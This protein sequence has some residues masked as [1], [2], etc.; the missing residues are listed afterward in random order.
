LAKSKK[1]ES[2]NH[3]A[4]E[5]IIMKVDI[6]CHIVPKRYLEAVRKIAPSGIPQQILIESTPT[7]T[8]LN[9]RFQIMDKYPD[10]V[11]V[12]TLASPPI[13]AIAG[14]KESAELARIANDEMAE[15]VSKHPQR[16][17]AA[18]GSL[19]M[20][21]VEAAL[22]ELDRVINGL[23][24]RGIQIYTNMN[25]KPIDSPEFIP[26]YQRMS[27]LNLPI[28]LHPKRE[29][30]TPDYVTEKR[31]KYLMNSIFGWPHETSLAMG[32]L[33][34]S[35]ILED[36]PN[37]KIITHHCGGM[38]PFFSDRIIGQYDYVT[39]YLKLKWKRPL[40]KHPIEY[41]RMFYNDTAVYGSTAALICG[42]KFFGSE[43]LLFGTDMPY[44]DEIGNRFIRETI[45]SIEEMDIPQS[46]KKRIFEDNARRLLHL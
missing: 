45:R 1:E 21:N 17:I 24:L 23:K 29:F 30:D 35:G 32:R 19:P 42:H 12:L 27:Q 14:P 40:L 41:F 46:D 16:F 9:I 11:Q 8:D 6:F 2:G 4:L 7:L 33:V 18:V 22:K 5:R 3:D 20:N 38:V 25:G 13:E 44:D 34:F 28:W 37:L 26:I 43:H 39:S 31:S 15:L 10:L 36:Y